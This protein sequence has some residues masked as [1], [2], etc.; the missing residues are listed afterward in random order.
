MRCHWYG[1]VEVGNW[2]SLCVD[3]WSGM[4]VTGWLLVVWWSS[5]GV[6]VGWVVWWCW[7]FKQKWWYVRDCWVLIGWVHCNRKKTKNNR[8]SY[9]GVVD[10]WGFFFLKGSVVEFV[11]I[12]VEV[13]SACVR[14]S[15]MLLGPKAQDMALCSQC[16]WLCCLYVG[17]C[18]FW[19][20]SLHRYVVADLK[21]F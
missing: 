13:P 7:F 19:V 11:S 9:S 20:W 5:S 21:C 4:L 6:V 18:I 16:C 10:S 8:K 3:C 12:V 15:R 17:I 1:V 14:R 2:V